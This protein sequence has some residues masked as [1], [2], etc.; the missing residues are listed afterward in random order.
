M[1]E[2]VVFAELVDLRP[3][4]VI[5]GKPPKNLTTESMLC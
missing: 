2:L 1:G 5:K 3:K 4:V